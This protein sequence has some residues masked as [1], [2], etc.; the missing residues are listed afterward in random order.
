MYISQNLSAKANT[1]RRFHAL[2]NKVYRMDIL[3]KAW[4]Q[5][6][7]NKGTAGID[8]VSISDIEN[9]GV[10][11]FL[12]EIQKELKEGRYKPIPV[13]R[14]YIPKKDGSRRPLGIPIIKDRVIQAAAK[15]VIEPIFEA[16][17]KDCSYGFRPKGSAHRALETI[18]RAYN[19]AGYFV[20]DADIK[21]YFD[22]INHDKLMILIRRRISDRRI[23]N[24][25][26]IPII[27]D[28][29]LSIMICG[30]Q[31]KSGSNSNYTG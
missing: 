26:Q 30:H 14:V 28:K 23:L 10:E 31:K 17:F 2:Y 13:K 5:V 1:G 18:F 24:G 3:K 8:E 6:K 7:R 11:E 29:K 19:T 15:I 12:T 20:L 27:Q 22:N 25:V 9:Q 16:D 4:K 21:S